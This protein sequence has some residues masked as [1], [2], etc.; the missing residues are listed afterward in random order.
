MRAGARCERLHSLTIPFPIGQTLALKNNYLTTAD[1]LRHV[2]KLPNLAV[3]DIQSNRINDANVV[4]VLAQMPSL[5]VLYLQGNELVKLVKQYRKTLIY[6]C[7]QLKYLDDRPV[8]EEERRRVDAW[9]K[10][11]DASCGDYKAAQEAERD[12][13]DAIRREKKERDERNFLLFE[14]MM[15]DGRRK[16]QEDEAVKARRG[17]DNN[18]EHE[19]NPFSGEKILPV[20]DCAFLQQQ[21]EKR[22]EAVVNSPD[23]FVSPSSGASDNNNTT[24]SQ[25]ATSNESNQSEGVGDVDERRLEVLHQCATV[26]SGGSSSRDVFVDS[27]FQVTRRERHEDSPACVPPPAPAVISSPTAPSSTPDTSSNAHSSSATVTHITIE[28]ERVE[29]TLPPAPSQVPST[30]SVNHTPVDELD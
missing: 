7:R 8:F 12:E 19:V 16:R 4:D 3:L 17:P 25:Q 28:Q 22:W 13:L 1:D 18:A 10:A 21:R 5:K 9:G 14:Q 24:D 15:I 30:S 23:V 6:R 26:G 20:Q 11:L 29:V 2:L 27:V